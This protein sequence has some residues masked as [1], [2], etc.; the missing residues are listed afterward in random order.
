MSD[1]VV[2]DETAHYEPTHLDLRYLQKL[3]KI[4]CGSERDKLLMNCLS[5]YQTKDNDNNRLNLQVNKKKKQKKTQR[6]KH[7]F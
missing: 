4:A 6:K 1:S 5:L 3:I 2:P 7:T